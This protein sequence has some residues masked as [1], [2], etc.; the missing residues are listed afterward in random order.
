V[1][2]CNSCAVSSEAWQAH[3]HAAQPAVAL[4]QVL[5]V[6]LPGAHDVKVDDKQGRGRR[7]VL[8]AVRLPVLDVPVTL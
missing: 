5:Q 7:G 2:K 1:P 8:A 3:L 4:V 6:A